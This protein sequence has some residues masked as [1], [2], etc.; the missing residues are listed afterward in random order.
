MKKQ[1]LTLLGLLSLGTA[2]SQTVLLSENFTGQVQP[3]GWTNDSLGFPCM[4]TWQ[5]NNPAARTITGASFDADFAIL[6]S[7]NYGSGAL[8]NSSLTTPSF[9]TIGFAGVDLNFSEQ[10]RAYTASSHDISYSV[11]GGA[12]WTSIRSGTASIG[13]PTPVLTTISLPA[14]ALGQANVK[15]KYT[16]V[17]DFGWWWAIDAIQIVGLNSCAGTPTA[18]SILGCPSNICANIPYDLTLTGATMGPGIT[19]QWLSSTDGTT[20]SP[21]AGATGTSLHDSTATAPIYYKVVV[22]CSNGGST[23]STAAVNVVSINPT[24][25]CYCIASNPACAGDFISAV[26][27]TSTTLNN[28]DSICNSAAN[29]AY[30][31]YPASGN[32]TASIQQGASYMLNVTTTSNNIVSVWIDY[33]RNGVFD[34][35][36]WTQVCTASSAGVANSVALNVPL[37]AVAGQTGM[38]LRS[39]SSG[40]QNDAVSACLDF[41]SGETEDY[42]ITITAAPACAG[43]PTAGTIAGCPSTICPNVPYNL[44]LSGNTVASG[45][46]FQWMSSTNGT[47]YTPIAGATGITLHD[48]TATAPIYYQVVVTCTNGGGTSTTPAVSVATVNPPTACYCTTSNPGCSGGFISAVSILGTTLNNVD[49]L[50]NTDPSFGAYTKYPAAGSTTTNLEQGL[51]YTISITTTEGD[52]ES[53]WIDYNRD[54]IFATNE[55]FQPTT[56]STMNVPTTAA[57]TVPPTASLGLTGMRV[58]SRLTGNTNDST[59]AC[60]SMGSGE[61]EDYA[62]TIIAPTGIKDNQ[63]ND[64]AIVPNPANDYVTIMLNKSGIRTEIVVTDMLGNNVLNKIE[65]NDSKVSINVANLANGIY[66]VNVGNQFGS[67]IKKLV[68]SK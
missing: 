20:F 45:I 6:D 61:T 1:L 63:S 42:I 16:Y 12:T 19:Y 23:A 57:F 36:E 49:S 29:G 35:A 2:V 31:Q 53:V 54:G 9:S 32:T 21:I 51:T 67:T 50:C 46:S 10:F 13:Y 66:L 41:F 39:R 56:G 22:T 7:D 17:G 52:I 15:I 24:S 37:T 25:V 3:A 60:L 38:R 40:S 55:W 68:V 47:N 34:A 4:Y 48:S 65:T 11:D 26:S 59:S 30:T 44:S 14:P 62:I 8:Q 64:F 33:D 58:R 43:T 18:G 27:I 5:F 28:V